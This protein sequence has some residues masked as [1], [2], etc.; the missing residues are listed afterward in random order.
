MGITGDIGDV[1]FKNGQLADA[2]AL[3][4]QGSTVN[5]K[6]VPDWIPAFKN[7]IHGVMIFSGD[8]QASVDKTLAEVSAI[9]RVG[10][11]DATIHEV[12][13]VVGAVRPENGHEQYVFI[14]SAVFSFVLFVL[15]VNI[16]FGFLDGIS[17]P[18]VEGFDIEKPGQGAVDPKV[19]L[20]GH[21]AILRPAWATDGSFL[22]F[23]Y[24]FQ[25]VP[26][27]NLFLKKNPLPTDSDGNRL[28]PE[29]GSELL[30]ARMVGR[31]KS[32]KFICSILMNSI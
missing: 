24:L 28:T 20:T 14:L 8:K 6:F 30:G 27:F 32:G 21:D 2:L 1:G 22:A 26:E 16:S 31:W 10:A 18:A 15:N 19:I 25:L 7:A 5:G 12:L 13:K 29:Q 3:G 9:L 17:N 11:H 23:R 4:D